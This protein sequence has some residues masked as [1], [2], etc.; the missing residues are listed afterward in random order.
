M[1]FTVYAVITGFNGKNVL[2]T[3]F[4]I[5]LQNVSLTNTWFSFMRFFF[6]MYLRNVC[7][8]FVSRYCAL[9][10]P[11]IMEWVKQKY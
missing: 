3:Y 7:L 9:Y 2:Q 1:Q 8:L 4:Y 11:A 6:F 5:F 10:V